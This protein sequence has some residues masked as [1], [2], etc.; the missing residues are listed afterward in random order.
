MLLILL[1]VLFLHI[2]PFFSLI[3]LL[4]LVSHCVL[5]LQWHETTSSL[6]QRVNIA[7][8]EYIDESAVSTYPPEQSHITTFVQNTRKKES[9][10]FLEQ[11]SPCMQQV[12]FLN[13]W[14]ASYT[15]SVLTESH[16]GTQTWPENTDQHLPASNLAPSKALAKEQHLPFPGKQYCSEKKLKN[17]FQ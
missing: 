16:I 17:I 12:N 15:F 9:K 10:L 7:N 11:T 13:H 14:N 5:L 1:S 4:Q 6:K 8:V 2:K 3:F